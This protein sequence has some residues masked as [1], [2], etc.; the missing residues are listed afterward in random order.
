M[1]LDALLACV[2]G[3]PMDCAQRAPTAVPGSMAAFMY[4]S[5]TFSKK[6]TICVR[7]IRPRYFFTGAMSGLE[8]STS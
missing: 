3:S 4:F 8:T 6:S 7:V 1:F 5:L 2:P